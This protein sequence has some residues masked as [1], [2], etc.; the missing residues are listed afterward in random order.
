MLTSSL[1]GIHLSAMLRRLAELFVNWTHPCD[2]KGVLEAMAICLESASAGLP[3]LCEPVEVAVVGRVCMRAVT[4]ASVPASVQEDLLVVNQFGPHLVAAADVSKLY[5]EQP[6]LMK[7]LVAQ[8]PNRSAHKPRKSSRSGSWG[9]GN[10][11]R[12]F[13]P[14]GDSLPPEAR[15]CL[16]EALAEG[17]GRQVTIVWDPPVMFILCHICMCMHVTLVP[18]HIT[19]RICISFLM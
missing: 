1:V 5:K 18:I 8:P 2:M 9:S 12:G 14:F 11:F 6:P 17:Q 19:C 4:F 16:V 3:S 10:F 7:V 13:P 15:G